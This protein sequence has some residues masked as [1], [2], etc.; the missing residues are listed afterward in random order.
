MHFFSKKIDSWDTLEIQSISGSQ[1]YSPL[2]NPKMVRVKYRLLTPF[3]NMLP[4]TTL[5]I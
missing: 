1:N 4:S 2:I 3:E 5:R